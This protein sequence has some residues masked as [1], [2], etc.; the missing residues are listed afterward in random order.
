LEEKANY[1]QDISELTAALS[2]KEVYIETFIGNYDKE[3]GLQNLINITIH[4]EE[5]ELL[6]KSSTCSIIYYKCYEMAGQEY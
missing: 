4:P 3:S 6:P 5:N 2:D 1:R